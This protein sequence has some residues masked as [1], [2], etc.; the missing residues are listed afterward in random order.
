MKF[1]VFTLL[2]EAA[3]KWNVRPA[4]IENGHSHTFNSLHASAFR[5]C[6]A[7]GAVD[8]FRGKGIAFHCKNGSRF[9]AGLFAC[10]KAGMVVMPVLHGTRNTEIETLMRESSIGIFLTEKENQFS[11]LSPYVKHRIGDDFDLYVFKNAEAVNIHK[12]FPELKTGAIK[13]G[14]QADLVVLN[15][16]PLQDINNTRSILY[17]LQLIT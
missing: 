15:K 13:P 3:A 6:V 16:N 11:F 8:D 7:L 17:V 4:V 5:L 1:Q 14:Y 10:A 9:I 12:I 2:E